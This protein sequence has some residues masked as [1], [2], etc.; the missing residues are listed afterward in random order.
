[1]NFASRFI[2]SRSPQC[3][4]IL[5]KFG[6][7]FRAK[8][9]NIECKLMG[10]I[11]FSEKFTVVTFISSQCS[12]NLQFF[13][14][15]FIADNEN[16]SYK[17]LGPNWGKNALIWGKQSSP[18]QKIFSVVPFVYSQYN[19]AC[20]VSQKALTVNF[21]SNCPILEPIKS[22]FQVFTSVFLFT[23]KFSS[24]CIISKIFLTQFASGFLRGGELITFN[25][26]M[27]S[28]TLC[29]ALRCYNPTYLKLND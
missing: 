24:S 6:K 20:A 12:I 13:R 29:E 11:F 14:K 17:L 23:Y 8:S 4:V 26:L 5:Q 1:M 7:I 22:F 9:K 19:I 2:L 25:V 3:P 27:Y 16:K 21:E 28:T 18:P 10:P 15:S